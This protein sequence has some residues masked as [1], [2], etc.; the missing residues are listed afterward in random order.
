M[1]SMLFSKFGIL[2]YTITLLLHFFT[3]LLEFSSPQGV[4]Q[5]VRALSH[6]SSYSTVAMYLRKT[7]IL[8]SR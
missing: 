8:T 1:F 5:G 2:L 7:L 4:S 3:L 6:S